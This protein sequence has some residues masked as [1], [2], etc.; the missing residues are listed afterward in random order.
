MAT[1]GFPEGSREFA[2][3]LTAGTG[4]GVVVG[5]GAFFA[6]FMFILTRLQSRFTR[7]DPH[8]AKEF[9]TASR[10]VKPGLICCGIVSAWTWSATLLQSSA[11]TY[12]SGT[13]QIAFFAAVA[14]KVK[15]NANGAVTFLQIA[16]SWLIR[17]NFVRARYGIACHLLF[18]FYALACAHIVTGSLVLGASSTIN[19]LT[20]A[21]VIAC[22]FLLPVGIAIYVLL[23]GLRATFLVDFVHTVVLFVIIYVFVFS[24]YGT[25]PVLGSPGKLYDLLQQAAELVPV[26][27]NIDGSYTTLKS[28]AGIL[29]AGC[30]ICTGFSGVFCDQVSPRKAQLQR[31]AAEGNTGQGYWQRAIASSSSSFIY[32]GLYSHSVPFLHSRP[33][34]TTKAYMLGGISWFAIPWAFGSV[35]GLGARALMTN[36]SFPTYPYA[37]SDAQ[38]SA[39]LVA[40]A[41][42]TTLLGKGGAVA[43][44]LV[45]FMAAT[46]A[47]SAELI[48]VSSIVT[49]DVVGL[50]RKTPLTARQ[51]V[52]LSHV[53]IAVYAIWAGAWSTILHKAGVDLGW[54]F[55][56]QG[57]ILTPAV[58]PIGLTVTWKKQSKHAAFWGTVIGSAAALV[59][60]YK[61]YGEINV[62]NLA[63][64]YSAISGPDNYDWQSTRAIAIA[65]EDSPAPSKVEQSTANDED[66]DEKKEISS[67]VAPK[68][69]I[70]NAASDSEDRTDDDEPDRETLQRVFVRASWFSSGL[71]L[72][73]TFIIPIPMFAAHYVFSRRFFEVWIGFSI[74]WVLVAGFFCMCVPSPP[75]L[76]TSQL[77]LTLPQ[78][79]GRSLLPIIESRHEML[80][81]ARSAIRVA[82]GKTNKEVVV[83]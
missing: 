15:Q 41:A 18:T 43:V 4:Y 17:L 23:G 67:P 21:D 77:E 5:V 65:M 61:V 71:T 75:L 40:P 42:A 33:D 19:A 20:G 58:V 74:V 46:S 66:F 62:T 7:L 29:F 30:T 69:A 73:V 28:N 81:I 45:V 37:L 70:D 63:L 68:L 9:I 47:A 39:G 57:V 32:R 35:M 59:G 44:L 25:S 51:S 22:N 82:L 14:A 16:K 64:P 56:V 72:L 12:Q 76:P 55:Y 8:S 6:I 52:I 10:S 1:S 13:I 31:E 38:V 36:P 78:L 54:L 3:L 34:S 49:F 27:G 26:A 48:A 60:C 2:R 50:L 80:I 24:A 79:G 83:A 53:V 11:A